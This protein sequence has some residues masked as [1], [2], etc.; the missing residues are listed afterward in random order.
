MKS[1]FQF[2]IFSLC[3]L[4]SCQNTTSKEL[5]LK[6]KQIELLKR[7]KELGD[8]EERIKVKDVSPKQNNKTNET[9]GDFNGDKIIESI[10]LVE[11]RQGDD[12]EEDQPIID[13]QI[14]FSNKAVPSIEDKNCFRLE[15]INE[16]DLD[17]DGGDELSIIQ[18]N[19]YNYD[20]FCLMK[21]M[22]LKNGKWQEILSFSVCFN[23]DNFV[24]FE[25]R[26]QK[27]GNGKIKYFE[28]KLKDG[29]EDDYSVDA[30]VNYR[31]ISKTMEI[32]N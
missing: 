24:S 17:G 28:A 22:T 26:I 4:L 32:N 19:R 25:S 14:V 27:I 6:N 5:E 1:I 10:K 15:F 31:D 29:H 16:G 7:E 13:C 11:K 8:R 20:P 21:C 9:S 30:G 18:K 12:A 2:N 3:L 23:V